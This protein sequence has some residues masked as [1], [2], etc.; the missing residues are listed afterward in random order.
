M[1][2]LLRAGRAAGVRVRSRVVLVAVVSANAALLLIGAAVPEAGLAQTPPF[3][4]RPPELYLFTTIPPNCD[5]LNPLGICYLGIDK[6]GFANP[7]AT[8]RSL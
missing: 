8:A 3:W 4:V 2:L 5:R 7:R 1:R 6:E